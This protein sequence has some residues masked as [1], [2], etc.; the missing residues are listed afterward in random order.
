MLDTSFT[1]EQRFSQVRDSLRQFIGALLPADRLRIGSFGSEVS[2]SPLLTGDKR[3]LTRV[4][5][6]E[7]WSGGLASPMWQAIDAAMASLA[8]QK[9]RRV[10][11]VLTDGKDTGALPGSRVTRRA[12]E[13]RARDE[14]FMIYGIGLQGRFGSDPGITFLADETGGG[15][16]ELDR[17]AD[18]ATT[19]ARVAD[20]LRHQYLLG[21]APTVQDGRTHRIEVRVSRPGLRVRARRNYVLSPR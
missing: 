6:E 13:K 14:G 5:Q 10:V 15:H 20:E 1:L 9:G 3:E 19:F 18:L 17:D 2:V 4:L 11:L 7:L 8:D 12:V 16:F 21:F